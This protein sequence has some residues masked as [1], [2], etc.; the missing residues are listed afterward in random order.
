MKHSVVSTAPPEIEADALVVGIY[1][2]AELPAAAQAIDAATDGAI[3]RLLEIGEFE[4]KPNEALSLHAPAGV[5]ANQVLLVGLGKQGEVTQQ[6]AFQATG[7]AAKTLASKPRK[8]VAFLLDESW[9]DELC[10][11][12][13]V[14][15]MCGCV[16]QDLYRAEKSTHP[17]EQAMWPTSFQSSINEGEAVGD[18]VNLTRLLVN[19][20]P[21][22]L[23]PES[24]ANHA[25]AMAKECGLE[26]EVWDETRLEKEGCGALMAVGKGSSRPPRLAIMRH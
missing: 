7:T 20:P 18:S 4:G 13:I 16:G 1:H 21:H 11:A 9:N 14:G 6:V 5:A 19:E 26:I 10:V 8:S 23:Y 3:S 15:A 25:V 24:F 22:A 17:I 2:Q 12:A